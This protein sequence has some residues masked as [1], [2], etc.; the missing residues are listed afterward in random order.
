VKER[1]QSHVIPVTELA[2]GGYDNLSLD[3]KSYKIRDDFALFLKRRAEL[4]ATAV[5]LIAD[6]HQ[7]SVREIY[8][9]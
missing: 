4:V 8:G 5:K 3:D 9:G 6:G 1:L 7:L 2:N